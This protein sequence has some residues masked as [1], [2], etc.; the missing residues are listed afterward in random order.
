MGKYSGLFLG[1][2]TLLQWP[3]VARGL[4]GS[5]PNHPKTIQQSRT[6]SFHLPSLPLLLMV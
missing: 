5:F 4:P 2:Y 1:D 6:L 3:T